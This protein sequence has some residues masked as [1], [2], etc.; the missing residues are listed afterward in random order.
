MAGCD[1]G[2]SREVHA[3]LVRAHLVRS[4]TARVGSR[5]LGMS[6]IARAILTFAGSHG[7]AV[8]KGYEVGGKGRSGDAPR[9]LEG[10]LPPVL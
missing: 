6:G 1:A 10:A 5:D 2:A 3:H 4:R 7:L 8:E 9:R